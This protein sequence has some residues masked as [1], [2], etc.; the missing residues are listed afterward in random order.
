MLGASVRQLA[1]NGTN[2]FVRRKA[3]TK[4]SHRSPSRPRRFDRRWRS[5]PIASRRSP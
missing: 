3:L 4:R 5:C 2:E 1:V